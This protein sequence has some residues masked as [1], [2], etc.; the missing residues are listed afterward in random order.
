VGYF[1]IY[2]SLKEKRD[3]YWENKLANDDLPAD[4][5][6]HRSLPITL[7]YQ[8]DQEDFINLALDQEINGHVYRVLKYRYE[9][10]TLHITFLKDTGNELLNKSFRDWSNTF[11]QKPVSQKNGSKN[12]L[13]FEK[14]YIPHFEYFNFPGHSD[15]KPVFH[16]PGKKDLLRN[17]REIPDPPPEKN[18]FS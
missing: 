6:L 18:I 11:A 17:Q 16:S 4:T 3:L 12:L 10:D 13:T 9:K 5:Y 2:Q 7:P 1:F 15:L 14:N 8:P